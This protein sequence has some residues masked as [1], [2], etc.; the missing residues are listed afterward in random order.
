MSF[1]AAAKN[2]CSL[3]VNVQS[4]DRTLRTVEADKDGSNI[5]MSELL[6]DEI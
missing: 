1:D 2:N 4:T 6:T 5:G 3:C